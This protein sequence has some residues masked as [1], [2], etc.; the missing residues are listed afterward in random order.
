MTFKFS[1]IV[2]KDGV[3]DNS[4]T[5]LFDPILS[6]IRDYLENLSKAEMNEEE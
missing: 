4:I 5:S 2:T 6:E 3:G 1:K